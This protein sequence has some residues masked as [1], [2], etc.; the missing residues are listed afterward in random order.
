MHDPISKFEAVVMRNFSKIWLFNRKR[1]DFKYTSMNEIRDV[2]IGYI[3]SVF[4][5][6]A[7]AKMDGL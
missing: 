6:P 2:K 5:I 4:Y 7:D 1:I 3:D